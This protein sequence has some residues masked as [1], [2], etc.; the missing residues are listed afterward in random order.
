MEG[1]RWWICHLRVVLP[2][3]GGNIDT[4][5]LGRCLERGHTSSTL[6]RRIV[7]SQIV[8]FPSRHGCRRPAGHLQR[9]RQR[10]SRRYRGAR[11]VR[12]GWLAVR[13]VICRD[14]CISN[15]GVSIKDIVHERAWVTANAFAVGVSQTAKPGALRSSFRQDERISRE[16]YDHTFSFNFTVSTDILWFW[17]SSPSFTLAKRLKISNCWQLYASKTAYN[18]KTLQKC[19]D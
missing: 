11:Q 13:I 9:H 15:L 8:T 14:R 7:N 16:Y 6:K 12:H 17:V 19:Q 5:L 10:P 3:C 4:T 18:Y 2:L 1:G